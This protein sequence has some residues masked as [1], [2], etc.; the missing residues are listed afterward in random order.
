MEETESET[1][2]LGTTIVAAFVPLPM[3]PN[4][5]IPVYNTLCGAYELPLMV[6]DRLRSLSATSL[7]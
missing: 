5:N 3:I 7:L 1:E 2:K 6:R 4:L